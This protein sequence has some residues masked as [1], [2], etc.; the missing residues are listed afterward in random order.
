M[1][2][3]IY[4][5]NWGIKTELY[6][7]VRHSAI[8]TWKCFPHNCPLHDYIIKWKHFPHYW[9]FVWGIQWSLVNSPQKRQWSRALMFSLICAWINSWVNNHQA[10]DL[11]RYLTHYDIT[12]MWEAS[13]DDQWIPHK[14]PVIWGFCFLCYQPEQAVEQT[15]KTQVI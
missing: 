8:M 11:R 3:S 14:G 2:Y 10:G 4:N 13:K 6:D 5:H 9:P 12:V 15:V 1:H 7:A